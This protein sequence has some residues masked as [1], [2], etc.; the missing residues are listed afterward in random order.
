[1][2]KDSAA[3]AKRVDDFGDAMDSAGD[4]AVGFSKVLRANVDDLEKW[5]GAIGDINDAVDNFAGTVGSKIP[6]VGKFF[7]DS[8]TDLIDAAGRAGLS[9][10]DL[11]KRIENGATSTKEFSDKLF[12]ARD[13]GAI[14]K[15]EF[16]D[17]S[18]AMTQYGGEVDKA[19][20][21]TDKMSKIMAVNAEEANGML[22]ELKRQQAP[23]EQY[24]ESWKT[25]VDDMAD[26]TINSEE[27]ADAINFLAEA[28]GKTREEVIALGKEQLDKQ[29]E[30]A[31]AKADAQ[32]DA[33]I[34]RL[35]KTGVAQPAP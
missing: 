16:Y 33:L 21:Q 4:D 12:A 14:N 2:A 11:S 10:Y 29:M 35:V 7:K 22:G 28:L 26:G 18:E 15:K 19:R 17:L 24:G 30:D 23:L 31:S 9:I 8:S 13:A 1:M 20:E 34:E 32:M 3:S 25:L 27:S 6:A 5:D